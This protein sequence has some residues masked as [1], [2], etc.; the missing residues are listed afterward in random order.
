MC[1]PVL[2]FQTHGHLFSCSKQLQKCYYE[3][4][5]GICIV[6]IPLLTQ[7]SYM[8]TCHWSKHKVC[9]FTCLNCNE[10]SGG[11]N[12]KTVSVERLVHWLIDY[13]LFYVPS[14]YLC[15]CRDGWWWDRQKPCPPFLLHPLPHRWAL[16]WL[17]SMSTQWKAGSVCINK[18]LLPGLE[19]G[20]SAW[21]SNKQAIN[22]ILS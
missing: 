19:P 6:F 18:M 13:I 16:L 3:Y 22:F 15:L 17:P 2:L 12:Y 14:A 10:S 5:Y 4:W 11:S 8:C 1:P 20:L 21:E 9:L 7:L